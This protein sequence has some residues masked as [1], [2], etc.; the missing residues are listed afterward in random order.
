MN[1]P[2]LA[3]NTPS[4]DDLCA[5]LINEKTKLENIQS[6]VR[7]AEKAIIAM[8]GT[9]TEGSFSVECDHFKVTTTQPIRRTVDKKLAQDLHQSL[10]KDIAESIF[11][12]KLSLS[13]KV[14]KDLEKYQPQTHAAIARAVTAKP[15]KVSVRVE[16]LA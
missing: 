2:A 8:V 6:N 13:T 11:D 16:A 9:R 15:G 5:H 1:Q 7:A 12:W 10:P 14:Y 3:T 4:L